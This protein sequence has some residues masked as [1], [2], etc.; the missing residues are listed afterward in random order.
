MLISDESDLTGSD[1]LPIDGSI[2]TFEMKSVL[3]V[4]WFSLYFFFRAR[5]TLTLV[6]F[7]TLCGV[8]SIKVVTM[9]QMIHKCGRQFGVR[10]DTEDMQTKRATIVAS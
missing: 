2:I 8:F 6:T 10:W 9:K 5:S 7:V 4:G 3:C 1:V